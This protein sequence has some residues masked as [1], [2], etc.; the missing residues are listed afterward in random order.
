MGVDAARRG[1]RWL[2]SC[3]ECRHRRS[4]GRFAWAIANGMKAARRTVAAFLA[5]PTI[6]RRSCAYER[7]RM[8]S[9]TAG[10]AALACR[11]SARTGSGGGQQGRKTGGNRQGRQGIARALYQAHAKRRR[12]SILH[13]VTRFSRPYGLSLLVGA[14]GKGVGVLQ[15]GAQGLRACRWRRRVPVRR[16]ELVKAKRYCLP[17]GQEFK[18]FVTSGWTFGGGGS[19]Q[20]GAGGK[21]AGQAGGGMPNIAH[22][23]LTKNGL[24]VGAAAADEVLEGQGPELTRRRQRSQVAKRGV[25][26]HRG[27]PRVCRVQSASYAD[28]ATRRAPETRVTARSPLAARRTVVRVVQVGFDPVEDDAEARAVRRFDARP[29]MLQ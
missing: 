29:Q 2:A 20:V 19:V 13:P 23:T 24:H 6:L 22:Y 14:G 4:V 5:M 27:A 16:S 7:T 12:R 26:C 9:L 18:Q 17:D 1:V 11:C 3:P 28:R 8:N 10:V 15:Q 21:S 25:A